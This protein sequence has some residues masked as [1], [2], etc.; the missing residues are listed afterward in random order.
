MFLCETKLRVQLIN[1]KTEALNFQHCFAVS[2]NGKGGGLAMMWSE[3]VTIDI[4]S[5][6]KHYIDAVAQSKEAAIG[7][8]HAY[9][10]I[11]K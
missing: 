9:T 6:S 10:A 8:A 5:Y 4:K 11:Q 1:K 3:N 2:S 7:D